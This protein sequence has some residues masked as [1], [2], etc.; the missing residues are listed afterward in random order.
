[1]SLIPDALSQNMNRQLLVAQKASPK[2]L[3]G[4]GIGAVIGGT[5]L[6]CRAT[7]K[8]ETKLDAFKTEI[9]GISCRKE[10]SAE[11]AY[12]TKQYK[13]DLSKAYTRHTIDIVRLYAPSVIIG[14]IGI[15]AL[16]TSHVTLTRRN[17]S[18]TA[19][20]SALS[21]SYDAYRA[22][23][24][25]EY[26]EERELELKQASMEST[27]LGGD[28][29]VMGLPDGI[30]HSV[31]ARIF[32][33]YS[34]RWVKDPEANKVFLMCQQNYANHRLHQ[35][36]HVFLNEIYDDLGLERTRA[37]QVVGWVLD[38][39]GDSYIDFGIFT[40]NNSR[41]V[42]GIE[43]SVVLDFNVDGLIYDKI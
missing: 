21:V 27:L 37:G 25:E 22:K 3:F 8:L 16:T 11:S 1:M 9:D 2:L 6:A 35:R 12:P 40:A 28:P 10:E 39:N 23:I 29:R 36:G 31:Y 42:N 33:E 5:I 14:G 13:R 26:G 4:L 19:A 15:A 43:R 32:D 20:Y 41:F 38:G 17:A 34:P 24:R 30:D 7:M 18:L